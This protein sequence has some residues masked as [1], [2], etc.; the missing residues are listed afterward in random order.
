MMNVGSAWV[1]RRKPGAAVVV[2]SA[3]AAGARD[4]AEFDDPCGGGVEA[5]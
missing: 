5:A 4:L 3:V 1:A 2:A